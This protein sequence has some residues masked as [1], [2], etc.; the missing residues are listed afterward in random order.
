M[1]ALVKKSTRLSGEVIIPGSK[2]YT[3]RVIAAAALYGSSTLIKNPSNSDANAAM[4]DVCRKL[5]ASVEWTDDKKNLQVKGFKG[6]PT[7]AQEISVGNSGTALRIAVA[8]ASLA[9]GKVTFTGDASLCN[10]PTKRLIDALNSLGAHV[11]GMS[12]PDDRGVMEEYAPI[13]IGPS[14]L[15]GG[16]ITISGEQ[17]SQYLTSL[18]LVS[19][20]AKNDVEI[21]ITG[22]LASKPYIE[23]TLE[24]LDEFGLKIDKSDDYRHFYIKNRQNYDKPSSYSIPG[25]YSQ[26]AFFLAAG[27]LVDSDITVKGL[28]PDDKQ[29]DKQII[30]ILNEMGAKIEQSTDGEAHVRGPFDLEGIEVDL[31]D[32]PDLFPVLSVLGVYAQGKMRLHNMPQIR[33]KE[34]DRIAVIEREFRRHGIR[35]E[36]DWDEMTVYHNNMPE[37][38]YDLSA[39]GNRGVSDHRVAMALSL[40]GI[41]SG[42]AI[43]R[44]ANSVRISYP[45]YFEHLHQ[46]GVETQIVEEN[47]ENAIPQNLAM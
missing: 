47:P 10:R 11:H 1:D 12:R 45:D 17:S 6:K 19:N 41:R 2:S 35:T 33:S 16:A 43:I 42:C 18:L 37:K 3:H 21:N 22:K 7:A 13:T 40:I 8:L 31:L 5:G 4:I 38:A 26:A 14:M 46:I 34:T 27:C 44:E 23:M 9:E 36:S 30:S 39:K 15:N 29:G 24:V 28:N 32:A 25:D 20:F